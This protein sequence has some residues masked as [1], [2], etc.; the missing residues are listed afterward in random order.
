MCSLLDASKESSSSHYSHKLFHPTSWI[1]ITFTT[2]KFP[3]FCSSNF[4][5]YLQASTVQSQATRLDV[6]CEIWA[7][8]K[9]MW[10]Y[11]KFSYY[12]FRFFLCWG[13]D[14]LL[15]VVC[16]GSWTNPS[17]EMG[18]PGF[19]LQKFRKY[20]GPS[21]PSPQLKTYLPS[22]IQ[23]FLTTACEARFINLR[24][25]KTSGCDPSEV[26]SEIVFI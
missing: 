20:P 15:A 19:L 11:D 6:V 4:L 25:F 7:T 9:Y 12:H 14:V 3:P 23:L 13:S 21:P 24:I 17:Q 2:S 1:S 16:E 10:L 8:R 22:Q 18:E 5:P 26:E